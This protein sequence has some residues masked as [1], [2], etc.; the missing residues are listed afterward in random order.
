MDDARGATNRILI[1]R[2]EQ[3]ITRYNTLLQIARDYANA[4]KGESSTLMILK[5]NIAH[6]AADVAAATK[7]F[8]AQAYSREGISKKDAEMKLEKL[9]TEK[10]EKGVR[11]SQEHKN[12]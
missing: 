6:R 4:L 2:V 8:Y 10:N 1:Q 11:S 12:T 3:H 5:V 9:L 7:I